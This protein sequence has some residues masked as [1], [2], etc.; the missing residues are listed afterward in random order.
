MPTRLN[1]LLSHATVVVCDREK[2]EGSGLQQL[3]GFQEAAKQEC[4]AHLRPFM[5]RCNYCDPKAA[6]CVLE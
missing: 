1:A 4:Q 3:T 5:H 6:S 2:L